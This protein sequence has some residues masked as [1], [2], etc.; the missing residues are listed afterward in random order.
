MEVQHLF[1]PPP[2]PLLP[3]QLARVASLML[4]R[5]WGLLLLLQVRPLQ[6]QLT[7]G[8]V[9]RK[10][11]TTAAPVGPVGGASPRQ[12][13]LRRQNKWGTTVFQHPPH[14]SKLTLL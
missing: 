11:M 6:L 4:R 9:W 1:L 13:H 12:L 5:C 14:L 2:L 8:Q 10:V 3:R 7:W